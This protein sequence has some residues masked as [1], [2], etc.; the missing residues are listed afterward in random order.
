M[1]TLNLPQLQDLQEL[2]IGQGILEDMEMADQIDASIKN[3][4]AGDEDELICL[5]IEN[6]DYLLGY[7]FAS[8]PT[9]AEEETPSSG[10]SEI[11][12]EGSQ[13]PHVIAYSVAEKKVDSAVKPKT[14]TSRK[15][16]YC[17]SSFGTSSEL[18]RHV[19]YRHTHEKRHQC[20][21]C[22]YASVELSKSQRHMRSRTGEKPYQCSICTYAAADNFK[23]KR[24]FHTHNGEKPYECDICHS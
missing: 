18:L 5:A 10:P 9:V 4:D 11:E 16:Q 12:P 21:Q 22:D 6:L 17:E 15:C 20:A 8:M 3:L 2:C 23:L 7:E 13:D 19:R 24:H 14:T 1:A